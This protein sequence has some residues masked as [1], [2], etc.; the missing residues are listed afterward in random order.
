MEIHE[1]HTYSEQRHTRKFAFP[2]YTI[3]LRT[4]LLCY[5]LYTTVMFPFLLSLLGNVYKSDYIYARKS[6]R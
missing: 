6:E 5:I 3:H 2:K 4:Y 1:S